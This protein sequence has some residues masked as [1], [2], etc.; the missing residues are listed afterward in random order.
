M[1]K[2]LAADVID[3]RR[4]AGVIVGTN[5]VAKADPDGYTC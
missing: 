4:G 3:N 1:A 5:A 2:G